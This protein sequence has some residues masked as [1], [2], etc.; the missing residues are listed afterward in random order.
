M[1]E[2]KI[3]ISNEEYDQFPTMMFC[4]ATSDESRKYLCCAKD[5]CRRGITTDHLFL[6]WLINNVKVSKRY[7]PQQFR[8]T[9]HSLRNENYSKII[10]VVKN[11]RT[12]IIRFGSPYGID[13]AAMP[14]L[15]KE[16]FWDPSINK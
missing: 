16:D 7:F 10:S 9:T 1:T 3:H 6:I 12:Q 2:K 14:I 4:I 13:M 15:S 8:Q 5:T 11:I